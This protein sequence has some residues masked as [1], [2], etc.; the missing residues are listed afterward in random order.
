MAL[1][2]PN[3]EMQKFPLQNVYVRIMSVDNNRILNG[4]N[5]VLEVHQ[6]DVTPGWVYGVDTRTLPF[7]PE[8]YTYAEAYEALK[9]SVGFAG[10]TD[11]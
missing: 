9:N 8:G 2:V 6:N 1:I 5:L 11:A 3:F 4:C 7:K 10:A